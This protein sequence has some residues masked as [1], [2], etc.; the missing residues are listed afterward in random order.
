M[1]PPI[2]RPVRALAATALFGSLILAVPSLAQTQTPPAQTRPAPTTPSTA[3]PVETRINVLH[4][5]LKI[6]SAQEAKWK[7]V[8]QVMRD[9]AQKMDGLMQKRGQSMRTMSAVDDLKSYREV[10]EAHTKGLQ[11][12]IPTFETLYKA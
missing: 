3:N 5:K 6:T 8:A 9:N 10:T 7:A 2:N 1:L 4:D 12:L 11:K